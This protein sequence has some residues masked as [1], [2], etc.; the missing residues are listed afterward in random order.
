MTINIALL[1]QLSKDEVIKATTLLEDIFIKQQKQLSLSNDNDSDIVLKLIESTDSINTQ[2]TILSGFAPNFQSQLFKKIPYKT[3]LQLLSKTTDSSMLVALFKHL[4][5]ATQ[6]NCLTDLFKLNEQ[7]HQQLKKAL[8]PNLQ[9]TEGIVIS[10]AKISHE[11][12]IVYANNL[13]QKVCTPT[14]SKEQL[15]NYSQ[16]MIDTLTEVNL[17]KVTEQFLT[18]Y[19]SKKIGLQKKE[20]FITQLHFFELSL[21]LI[22]INPELMPLFDKNLEHFLTQLQSL[23]SDE[24]VAKILDQLP[25]FVLKKA[26]TRLKD[27]ERIADGLKRSQFCKYYKIIES[28]QNQFKGIKIALEELK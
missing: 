2:Y 7:K 9:I 23:P 15:L 11:Q 20:D 26:C 6:Q 3:Q 24:W 4:D 27:Y 5:P 19:S 12:C 18:L 22:L 8:I 10:K 28:Y 14:L 25:L 13:L 1:E 16:K 21:S 17:K